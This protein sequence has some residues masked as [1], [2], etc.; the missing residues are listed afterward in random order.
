MS[1]LRYAYNTNGLAHHRLDDALALL[2]D[3]GYVGCALT[4]DHGH[5][6]PFAPD[7]MAQA[8]AIGRRARALGLALVVETGARF[9]LDPRRKHEPTLVS[10]APDGRERRLAFLR[11]A[12]DLAVEL[13]APVLSLWSGVR[14]ADVAETDAWSWLVAGIARTLEHAARAR[15]VLGFEPEPG[16]VV[17]GLDD[18]TRL[19][20]ECPA[21]KLTLDLGHVLLTE[22]DPPAEVVRR[23]GSE[24]VNVHAEDMRR[25]VHEH[26]MF[27]DGE[28]DYAPILAALS[29]VGY[30]GLV[31]VELSRD[32]HRGAD[33]AR[34]ALAHLRA[35]ER[36]Q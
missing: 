6:D 32:S 13:E 23:C 24:L 3:L 5:L 21:L 14:A 31:A 20:R 34:H 10:A 9:L 19:R 35:A 30:G 16:M 15:V 11:L 22:S 4:L 26:L 7:A 1:G 2:A 27:G 29:A 17:A 33:A 8:R 28:M 36:S 18:W 12:I 25:G